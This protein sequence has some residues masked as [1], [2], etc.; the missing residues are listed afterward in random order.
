M[1]F[2]GPFE[3]RLAIHELVASYADAI[4]VRDGDAWK[5]LWAEDSEWCLPLIPGMES[6]KGRDAIYGAWS[7]AMKDF[8]EMVG[9]ASL[10]MLEVTGEEAKGRAYP[11]E[12]II[13]P[14]G[15]TSTD[16]GRYDDEYIKQD[17]RWLFKSRTHSI[18]YSG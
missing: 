11:R 4:T 2:T 14:D 9:A 10:G 8:P 17:G 15:T 5:S 12:L 18:L 7:A 1:S 13:S 16:Y 3:D 6:I